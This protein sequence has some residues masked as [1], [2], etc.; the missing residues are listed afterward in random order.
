MASRC[1]WCRHLA[2]KNALFDPFLASTTRRRPPRD[3]LYPRGSSLGSAPRSSASREVFETQV[4]ERL[5]GPWVDEPASTARPSPRGDREGAGEFSATMR[6]KRESSSTS[7]PHQ[8]GD[9]IADWDRSQVQSAQRL[10]CPPQDRVAV[11][12]KLE[13][14]LT[15][16]TPKVRAAATSRSPGVVHQLRRHAANAWSGI[17]ATSSSQMIC[18]NK[19]VD[20]VVIWAT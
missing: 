13:G 1:T 3:R 2:E 19:R 12:E 5:G 17:L 11:I 16:R 14:C 6:G 10:L 9:F 8:D 7:E 4:I 18:R 15:A 20:G